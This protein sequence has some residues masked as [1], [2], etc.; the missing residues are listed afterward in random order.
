[1]SS[2]SQWVPREGELIHLNCM[3]PNEFSVSDWVLRK[4]K[5]IQHCV[6]MEYGF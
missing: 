1:M 2:N 6:G 3:L 5:E 4:V